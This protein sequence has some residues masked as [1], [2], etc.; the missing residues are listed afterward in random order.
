MMFCISV[1]LFLLK[2]S[3]FFFSGHALMLF[4]L[5]LYFSGLRCLLLLKLVR[6][7]IIMKLYCRFGFATDWFCYIYS[8]HIPV[9]CCGLLRR[10]GPLQKCS[11][12]FVRDATDCKKGIGQLLTED[13]LLV[14]K[15]CWSMRLRPNWICQEGVGK[16]RCE[17]RSLFCSAWAMWIWLSTCLPNGRMSPAWL[18]LTAGK[19]VSFNLL[20]NPLTYGPELPMQECVPIHKAID[21][22]CIGDEKMII[23]EL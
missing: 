1:C 2:H 4:L 12:C 11:V 13:Q 9:W 19:P 22:E 10:R 20:G 7:F 21:L 23:L 18:W 16:N 15:E 8:C 3:A 17:R 5:K 14:R 6:V